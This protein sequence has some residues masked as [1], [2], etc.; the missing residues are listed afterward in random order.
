MSDSNEEPRFFY[1]LRHQKVE[2]GDDLCR[3]R[4]RLGPYQ[5]KA[6]AEEALENVRRRNEAW[7]EED[8]RWE[9]EDRQWSD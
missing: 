1:C 2:S 9:G 3:A 4:D 7:E 6:E 8:E 5:T